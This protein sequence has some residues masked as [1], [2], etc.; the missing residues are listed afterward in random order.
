[1]DQAK[2]LKA[3]KSENTGW[4]KLAADQAVDIAILKEASSGTF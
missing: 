1:M 3:L 4:K 2:R